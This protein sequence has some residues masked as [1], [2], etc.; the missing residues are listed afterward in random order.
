[1]N[2]KSKLFRELEL[3]FKKNFKS[4]DYFVCVYGSYA[5]NDFTKNSDLDLFIATENHNTVDFDKVR[6][7]V[8]D[9]HVRNNLKINEEVPYT[10]KLVMSYKDLV[11]AISLKAFIKNGSKYL[12]PPVTEDKKFLGS[13]A[14]RLRIILNALTSPHQYICGNKKKYTAS[15]QKAE[16]AI[17]L[18]A[19]GLTKKNNLTQ[20]KI[21]EVLLRGAH[22]EEGGVYLGYRPKRVRVVRYLK[23]LISRNSIY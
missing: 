21:L 12:I 20:D 11:D 14:V 13:R 16:T 5:S 6:D 2:I 17:M 3:F 9:L 1:M 15:K 10:N 22:G 8:V 23:E 4:R 7:F 18:L 19:C